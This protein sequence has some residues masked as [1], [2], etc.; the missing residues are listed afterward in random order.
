[1]KK[2][3]IYQMSKTEIANFCETHNTK[4]A[5]CDGIYHE[6]NYAECTEGLC[7]TVDFVGSDFSEELESGGYP[8]TDY[9]LDDDKLFLMN[10]KGEVMKK[11]ITEQD[12]AL[13]AEFMGWK[14]YDDIECYETPH[15]ICKADDLYDATIEDW[16]S[17]IKPE[18]MKFNSSWDWLMPVVRK[19]MSV[20]DDTDEWD[21]LYDALST[22][23]ITE[24]CQAAEKF[25]KWYNEQEKDETK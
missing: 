19:C 10:P 16:T 17:T 2:V 24:A 25:I 23:D 20:G 3:R 4:V 5:I 12:S 11:E 13:F 1:M 8:Y 7:N 21:A 22:I 6:G 18:D 14:Y 9:L 15:V